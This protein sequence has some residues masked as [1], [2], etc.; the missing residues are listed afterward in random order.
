RAPDLIGPELARRVGAPYVIA[1]ASRSPRQAHGPFAGGFA[2]AAKA[3]DSAR[4]IFAMT[5][6]DRSML[7]RQRRDSQSIVDLKPFLDVADWPEAGQSRVP[8][9][10]P[11]RLL[12]VAMM[13]HGDKTSSYRQLAQAMALLGPRDW[14]ADIVGD[15]VNRKEIAS[16]FAPFGSRVTFHGLIEDRAA[17]SRRYQ[18]A[19]VFVWPGVNE[20]YGMVYL[21][22]QAHGVPCVA[23]AYGGVA[24][25]VRH[26]ETGLLVEKDDPG[27]FAAAVAALLD[28]E[29]RRQCMSEAAARFVRRERAIESAAEIVR[30]ALQ[31][32]AVMPQAAS[33]QNA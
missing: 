18:K 29:S 8:A 14:R 28:N 12:T 30:S 11:P 25:V 33:A 5:A 24:D 26:G 15:G 23:G 16:L 2:Q 3:I 7:D 21:E 4:A 27:A 31:A 6:N 19:D 1:E 17:L 20:A 32:S 13:R 9:H 22:A 10:A